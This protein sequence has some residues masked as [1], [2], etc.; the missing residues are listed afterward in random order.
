[1]KEFVGRTAVVTGAGSGIGQGLARHAA[2]EGMHVVVADVEASAPSTAP[3]DELR[4]G[5][6][7]VLAVPTDVT[8]AAAL[9]A[10]ADAAYE[11]FGASTC[12]ATT[13]GSSRPAWCGSARSP[14]GTG[15][16]A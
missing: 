13:P 3:S 7:E 12:C 15:S 6:A 11:R 5:G 1:M 8:D 2:Q 16:W 10:L 9:E 4:D 14:T